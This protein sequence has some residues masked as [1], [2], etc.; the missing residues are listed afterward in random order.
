MIARSFFLLL[1]GFA[2]AACAS[3]VEGTDQSIAVNLSPEEATCVVT[4]EGAR[5][6]TISKDHKFLNISKSKNDLI[7]E[8]EALGYHDETIILESSASGWGVVGCVLID[9]CITDYSTGA[10]NKYPE[11]LTITLVPTSFDS[12]ESRDS[13]YNGRRQEVMERWDELIE[14]KSESCK[15]EINKTECQTR[16]SELEEQKSEELEVLEQR[17]LDSKVVADGSQQKSI[18]ERLAALKSLYDQGLITED[19]YNAKR[20]QI[21]AEF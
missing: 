1:L 21:L 19:E 14:E 13:W 2:V 12:I 5:L 8:C 9:L 18:D 7:I 4:R 17:R 11:T 10:L 3:I 15:K 20:S 6:S 16:V